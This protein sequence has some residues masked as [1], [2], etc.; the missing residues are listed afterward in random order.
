MRSWFVSGCFP[1]YGEFRMMLT[2]NSFFIALVL[3]WLS[4]C[5]ACDLKTRQV[6]NLLT[7]IPLVLAGIWRLISGDWQLTLLV[8]ALILISDLPKAGWRIPFGILAAFIAAG[9]AGFTEKTPQIVVL[10]VVWAMWERGLLGGADAKIILALVLLFADGRLLL[11]I[12]IAG[13]FQGLVALIINRRQIPYTLSIAIGSI[14]W[15]AL[16]R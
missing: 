3:I 14:V 16:I 7:L 11:L 6:P 8:I 12:L 15:M 1:V 5:V 13:G 10:F 2:L 9:F 4:V